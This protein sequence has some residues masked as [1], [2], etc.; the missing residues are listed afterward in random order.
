LAR[1]IILKDKDLRAF[2]LDNKLASILSGCLIFLFVLF[3]YISEVADSALKERDRLKFVY[4]HQTRTVEELKERIVALEKD[5]QS[6]LDSLRNREPPPQSP[7]N[8]HQS[9]DAKPPR[10]PR[11]K[12]PDDI[13]I[14]FYIEQRLRS[15]EQDGK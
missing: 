11:S 2:L 4:E 12:S 15:L 1:E 10:R 13:S 7:T 8:H 9:S 6:L 14:K 5:K 3:L